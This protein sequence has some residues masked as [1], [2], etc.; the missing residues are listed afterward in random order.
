[1]RQMRYLR[2]S[3]SFFDTVWNPGNCDSLVLQKNA[4]GSYELATD[5]LAGKSV[6]SPVR[7]RPSKAFDFVEDDE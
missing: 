3:V 1:M 6:T 2:W 4:K 7:S 5:V